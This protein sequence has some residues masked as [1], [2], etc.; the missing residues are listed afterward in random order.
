MVVDVCWKPISRPQLST[1]DR[2]V[3]WNIYLDLDL[4][5]RLVDPNIVD[6]CT[7]SVR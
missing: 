6:R 5:I 2:I 3:R 4:A 7:G 1:L